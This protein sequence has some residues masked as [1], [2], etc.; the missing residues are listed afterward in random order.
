MT[1]KS[2][3][4]ALMIPQL[5]AAPAALTTEKQALLMA[6][7]SNGQQLAAMQWKQKVTVVRK[8][9]AMTPVVEEIRF[10]A[11]GQMRRTTLA[12]PE[13]KRMGPLK[14]RKAAEVK[15]TI[16]EAMQLARQY[17]DPRT[18]AQ[19]VERGELWQGQHNLRIQA[20]SLLLPGDDVSVAASAATYLATRADCKTQHEG[21]PIS[22][23]IDY[24]QLPN[25]PSVMRRMI[26]QFPKDDIAVH[27]ESFDFVRLAA[28]TIP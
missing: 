16:E 19:A 27:V 4:A 25:G 2:L 17:A 12:G 20:R 21:D 23:A 7:R 24:E 14:A 22:I 6:L 18:F 5:A 9:T 3:L 11:T 1:N 13:P 26:V 10:D 8:G 15:D 28:P